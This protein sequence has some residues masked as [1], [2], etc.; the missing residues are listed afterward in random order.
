MKFS[1]PYMKTAGG[2]EIQFQAFLT[3]ELDGGEWSASRNGL[4]IPGNIPIPA[5]KE[6]GWAS[7]PV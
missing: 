6:V 4:F 7:K 1:R 3:S 2:M 5:G